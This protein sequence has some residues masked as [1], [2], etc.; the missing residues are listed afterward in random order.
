M[1]FKKKCTEIDVYTM[2]WG[3]PELYRTI[4]IPKYNYNSFEEQCFQL[5][6]TDPDYAIIQFYMEL[7]MA[8]NSNLNINLLKVDF[9]EV[10][11]TFNRIEYMRTVSAVWD[12]WF[13]TKPKWITMTL[14]SCSSLALTNRMLQ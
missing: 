9:D 5:S 13:T 3:Y 7:Q 6:C 14:S 1:T 11:K 4:N 10:F 2:I 8:F 12:I